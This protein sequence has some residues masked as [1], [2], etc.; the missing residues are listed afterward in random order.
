MTASHR[1]LVQRGRQHE[2]AQGKDLRA[3]KVTQIPD[4]D[5]LQEVFIQCSF[6][7]MVQLP[8]VGVIALDN[9]TSLFC[10]EM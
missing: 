1:V 7:T 5:G 6:A 4:R 9:A 8:R 2:P 3:G 10:R